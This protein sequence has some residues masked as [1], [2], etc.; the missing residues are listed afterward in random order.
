MVNVR[1]YIQDKAKAIFAA[2]VERAVVEELEFGS[3]KLANEFVRRITVYPPEGPGN[4]PPMPYWERGT[5]RITAGGVNP[6]SQNFKDS[7]DVQG[8]KTPFGGKVT[9]TTTVTYAPWLISDARQAGFHARNGWKTQ[10]TVLQEMG[11]E[12][13]TAGNVTTVTAADGF[14]ANILA[15]VEAIFRR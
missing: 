1:A 11:V 5:G 15:K 4:R 12:S 9:A 6:A 3:R 14:F 7:W 13:Q 10:G 2:S 8:F